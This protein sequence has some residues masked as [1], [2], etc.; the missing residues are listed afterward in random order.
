MVSH[1]SHGLSSQQSD[2]N[3]YRVYRQPWEV[4][5]PQEAHL[6][7]TAQSRSCCPEEGAP[8][9]SW[10]RECSF[11][12]RKAA[13]V[14]SQGGASASFMLNK[15][16]LRRRQRVRVTNGK[17]LPLLTHKFPGTLVQG[18]QHLH[19]NLGGAGVSAGTSHQGPAE[20]PWACSLGGEGA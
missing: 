13:P 12:E 20:G 4:L 19:L 9:P 6:G 2:L 11:P 14:C 3:T 1:E 15:C 5:G 8:G 7:P 10:T 18:A 17:T 16:A